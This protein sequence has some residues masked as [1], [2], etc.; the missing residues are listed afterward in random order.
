[1]KGEFGTDIRHKNATSPSQ[2]AFVAEFPKALTFQMTVDLTHVYFVSRRFAAQKGWPRL[3][4]TDGSGAARH[5]ARN[6][7]LCSPGVVRERGLWIAYAPSVRK[8]LL[9]PI[10]WA[11]R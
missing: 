6:R 7:R 9:R 2:L 10:Q 11:S 1:M 8:P 3:C 4:P 5:R